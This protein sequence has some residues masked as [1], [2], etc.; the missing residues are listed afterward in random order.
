MSLAGRTTER[1]TRLAT[2]DVKTSR[3]VHEPG[4]GF[5]DR[6]R[7]FVV[8]RSSAIIIAAIPA[9][10]LSMAI[11][12]LL[13]RAGI[14]HEYG[15]DYQVY[16]WAVHTWLAGGDLMNSA[17]TVS[18]GAVLPWVYP[19]FALLP[20]MPFALLPFRVGLLALFVV[21]LLAIGAVL[22]LVTRRLWPA[23]GARGAAAVATSALAVAPFLE[24]VYSSFGLGQI[25][26]VLMGL[27]ALDTLTRKPWWPRGLLVG[28]AAAIKLTPAAFLLFFLVNRQFRATVVAVL[29]AA[30]ASLAG[31][32]LNFSAAV[33]YWFGSGPASGVS[34]STFHTNQSIRGGLSR[35][36]MPEAAETTLWFVG[37]LVCAGI[38]AFAI[39]RLDTV[40]GLLA[41]A[42]LSLLASPTSW[43][44]HW[45]WCAPALLVMFGY[46]VRTRKVGWWVVAVVTLLLTVSATFQFV[47]AGDPWTKTQ[48]VIGNPFLIWSGVLILL[49]GWRA[50]RTKPSPERSES[51]EESDMAY[52][53]ERS[54]AR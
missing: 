14:S 51:L 17:P 53:R 10:L 18:S 29:T 34:G 50:W 20:L 8:R 12:V 9:T 39:W 48:H 28:I 54:A 36:G 46:A 24:P 41:T 26:V 1:T 19:P 4:R 5:R 49:L 52:E 23:V 11:M 35:L 7:A 13:G 21:D 47:P 16:R 2:V 31:F 42:L 27:V 15:I 3:A 45:V 25:N 30:V 6:M 44:D 37:C 32:A 43:S 33:D 38:V 22:Y 40:L